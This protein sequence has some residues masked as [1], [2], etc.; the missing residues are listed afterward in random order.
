M[1]NPFADRPLEDDV[2]PV[3]ATF[4]V[5]KEELVSSS[6]GGTPSAG[7]SDGPTAH[8]TRGL[9]EYSSRLDCLARRRR[10]PIRAAGVGEGG[11]RAQGITEK[12]AGLYMQDPAIS[13][14]MESIRESAR[15]YVV[16]REEVE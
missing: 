8:V 4:G 6:S 15:R 3:A 7:G 1:R 9:G 12:L 11:R 10:L 14:A 16:S 13:A 2:L 5:I